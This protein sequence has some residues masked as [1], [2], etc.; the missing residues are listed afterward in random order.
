[1]DFI[2][3]AE[4]QSLLPTLDKEEHDQLEANILA[5][6]HVDPLVVLKI[7]GEPQKVLGDGHHRYHI[8]TKRGIEFTTVVRKF[9]SRELAIQWVIDNQ[10]GRR[11]L[12]DE[13]RSFYRGKEYLNKKPAAQRPENKSATVADLSA[14]AAQIAGKHGVSERTI[15]NDAAFP[16]AVDELPPKQKEAVWEGQ[17]GRTKKEIAEGKK[18]ILCDRCKRVG[19]RMGCEKCA[20]LRRD[21][22]KKKVEPGKS[23]PAENADLPKSV[24]SALADT[25]HADCAS[26]LATL[27][28][29]C[30]SA[31]SWSVYLDAAILDRLK[32]AEDLFL[33]AMP[34]KKCPD[35]KGQKKVGKENCKRCR[36]SVYLASQVT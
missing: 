30:K 20:E 1:M 29:E 22:R 4:I 31:F 34:R 6:L 21:A 26:K 32:E 8:C 12:T 27:R 10:L 7:E 15:H 33:T 24:R 3:D 5:S 2:L 14:P 36:A 23:K 18:P 9:A 13:R 35:C 16:E 28:R 19:A 25:W 17:S 11:N